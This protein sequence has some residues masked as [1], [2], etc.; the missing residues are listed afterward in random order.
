MRKSTNANFPP[1]KLPKPKPVPTKKPPFCRNFY[2]IKIYF[3][4]IKYY[5]VYIDTVPELA[6]FHTT[7][8]YNSTLL[9]KFG[10]SKF[11]RDLTQGVVRYY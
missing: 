10:H 8:R 2:R 1:K 4:V 3:T 9:I 7:N 11:D 6:T 5:V